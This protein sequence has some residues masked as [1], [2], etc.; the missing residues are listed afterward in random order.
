M[1]CCTEG[2][3]VQREGKSVRYLAFHERR[4]AFVSFNLLCNRLRGVERA[5]LD[6]T[7]LTLDRERLALRNQRGTSSKEGSDRI[8][9]SCR[10]FQKTM[11]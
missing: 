4:F 9:K 6:S 10:V 1:I 11:T 3:G 7:S 5:F 2:N 8:I